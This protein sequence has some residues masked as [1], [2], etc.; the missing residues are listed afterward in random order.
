MTKCTFCN[1][2]LRKGLSPACADLCPTGA[3]SVTEAVGDEVMEGGEGFPEAGIGPSIQIIPLRDGG[4]APESSLPAET[5][6]YTGAKDPAIALGLR[7]EWPLAVFTF[8]AATLFGM[9]AAS[10][11]TGLRVHPA[12]FLAT[13]IVAMIVSGAVCST[14]GNRG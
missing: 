14:S 11:W 13:A 8:L 4:R 6:R 5:P 10:A 9:V 3:L 2:R 12:L 7:S 1:E